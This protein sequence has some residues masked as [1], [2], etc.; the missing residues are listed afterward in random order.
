M[1]QQN[2]GFSKRLRNAIKAKGLL[3]KEL[4]AKVGVQNH[5]MSKYCSKGGV[6]EWH[7]L[8]PIAKELDLSIEYLLTGERPLVVAGYKDWIT[9]PESAPRPLEAA[10]R[11]LLG[12][13]LEVLRSPGVPGKPDEALVQDIIAFHG[14]VEMARSMK[15][16][17]K[18][19]NGPSRD[20]SKQ[21]KKASSA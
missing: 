3:Q 16:G 11:K 10:E 19:A 12:Q 17:A 1:A 21:R 13:A 7:I 18:R 9:L 15:D 8:V 5:T 20:Q 14:S 6:P 4:S 2:Q